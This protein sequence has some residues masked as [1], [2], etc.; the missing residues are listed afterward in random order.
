MVL[1][2]RDGDRLRY[3]A[4]DD[5]GGEDRNAHLKVK[6]FTGRKYVLRIRMYYAEHEE[7]TAVM[8]W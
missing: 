4:G 6:L 1:F 3:L 8:L 7:E 2:E 5:D